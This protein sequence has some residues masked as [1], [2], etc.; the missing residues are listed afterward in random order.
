MNFKR[1]QQAHVSRPP[2]VPHLCNL[3]ASAFTIPD[4]GESSWDGGSVASVPTK[5]S[6]RSGLS[7]A[8]P[9]PGLLLP[10][11]ALPGQFLFKCQP[12]FPRTHT[13]TH[14]QGT[15]KDKNKRKPTNNGTE[16][17]TPQLTTQVSP[18]LPPPPP[19]PPPPDFAIFLPFLL[20]RGDGARRQPRGPAPTPRLPARPSRFA[21]TPQRLPPRPA[22]TS[23]R[24]RGP[25]EAKQR[26]SGE[27]GGA[28]PTQSARPPLAL[29]LEAGRQRAGPAEPAVLLV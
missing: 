11:P 27:R 20:S 12:R 5:T 28:G 6:F 22:P 24:E 13:Q 1:D 16:A 9:R 10:L 21:P 14:T 17:P 3:Q 19:P 4:D 8:A 7:A 15:Q 25:G 23:C 29:P 2:L 26:G 18:P